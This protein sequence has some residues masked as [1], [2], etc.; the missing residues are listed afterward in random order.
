MNIG[1]L[2]YHWRAISLKARGWLGVYVFHPFLIGRFATY[3][4]A[5]RKDLFS[6]NPFGK[7]NIEA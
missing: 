1:G 2:E 4:L 6:I 7:N 3:P 5:V